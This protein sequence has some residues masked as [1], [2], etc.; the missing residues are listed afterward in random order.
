MRVPDEPVPDQTAAYTTPRPDVFA[1]VPASARAI[2]DVGCSNGSLGASL[3]RASSGR[4]VFGVEIDPAFAAEARGRLDHVAC[5]D[6]NQWDWDG[7]MP[8][9]QFDCIIFADVLEHV[10]APGS[11]LMAAQRRLSSGGCIVIS[12]PNIRHLSSFHSIFLKG[13]F[14]Q[15][16]RGIFDRTHLRWFT[17]Q[18]ARDLIAT[19]GMRVDAIS[20]ALRVGDL[21][22][23]VLNRLLN[24][25]PA[26][27]QRFGLV[28]ELLTYQFCLR[29]SVAART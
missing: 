5:A 28:R 11:H 23:G 20:Y 19:Q 16:E 14:P 27:F 9:Q 22:G 25:M 3:R 13:T 10:I 1:M 7:F 18:D 6:L 21:G 24:R 4:L 29:T 15:R 17:I 26:S 12:L 8:G 2:L